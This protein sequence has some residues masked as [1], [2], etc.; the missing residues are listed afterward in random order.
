MP[1]TLKG[2]YRALEKALKKVNKEQRMVIDAELEE[3]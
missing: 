2:S 3:W 1:S